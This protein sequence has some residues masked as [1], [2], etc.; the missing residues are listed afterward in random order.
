MTLDS[1]PSSDSSPMFSKIRV[2]HLTLKNRLMMGPIAT[3]LENEKDFSELA[4]FYAERAKG[5]TA[6]LTIGGFS[7][8]VLGARFFGQARFDKNSQINEHRKL[9]KAIH[10]EGSYVLFQLS[11]VGADADHWFALNHTTNSKEETKIAWRMHK[12][13]ICRTIQKAARTALLAKMSHYDGIELDISQNHLFNS[14]ATPGL[15]HRRD[16]WG[17]SDH[18]RFKFAIETVKQIREYVGAEFVISARVSLLDFHRFGKTWQETI[19]FANELVKAGV[20][21]FSF[22]FGV[23][24]MNIPVAHGL[25]PEDAWLPFIELFREEVPVPVVFGGNLHSPKL[26]NNI[27]SNNPNSMVE[28]THALIVDPL[29]IKKTQYHKE[30]RIISCTMCNNGCTPHQVTHGQKL[31][32]MMNPVLFTKQKVDSSKVSATKK[33]LVI[34]AGPAGLAAAVFA[35]RRGH[36]VTIY[37]AQ[38]DIGGQVRYCSKIPGK[39]QYV[40]LIDMFR[41]LCNN[42]D[43]EIETNHKVTPLEIEDIR[44]DFDEVVYAAG[45]IP[46]WIDIQG[47]PSSKVYQY[48]DI[49][50]Q[51][52]P[53]IGNRVA[54]IG[55]NNIAIDV[56]TF[57]VHQNNQI[58]SRDEWLQIWGIGDPRKHRAGVVGMIPKTMTPFRNVALL[59]RNSGSFSSHIQEEFRT[60][61]MQWLRILGIKTFN[62]VNLDSYDSTSLHISFGKNH[63]D[64]TPI[65]IDHIVIC[66][67][68]NPNIELAKRMTDAGLN[69][70][71]IGAASVGEKEKIVKPILTCIREGLRIGC[72]L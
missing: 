39:E 31:S 42:F 63:D 15:N 72:S 13:L 24:S 22:N 37:E 64:S 32:C 8:S 23:G 60:F 68:P 56:A 67:T 7:F 27:L 53:P 14:F 70:H 21:L 6:L 41:K 50:Q 1:Y 18:N 16:E 65:P 12:F 58:P 4:Q 55:N 19:S 45:S 26:V 51:D 40:H 46:D 44:T 36:K 38:D 71:I 2:G 52:S 48:P 28:I 62:D 9:T 10:N 17:G 20:D 61:E 47:A 35:A 49:F 11:H 33:I 30:R 69:T 34:G 43:I 66:T 57:L 54:V 5:D 3:G 25:T 59:A 29:W